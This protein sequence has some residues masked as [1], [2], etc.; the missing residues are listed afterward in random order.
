MHAKS[1]SRFISAVT[2]VAFT[3]CSLV[4]P[5]AQALAA[6][7]V[8]RFDTG[9]Y[10]VHSIDWESLG[11][12]PAKPSSKRGNDGSGPFSLISGDIAAQAL[13]IPSAEMASI[14]FTFPSNLPIVFA[15]YTPGANILR[16]D[17]FT[18]RKANG[19]TMAL[20][21][22]FGPEQ[23]TLWGAQRTYQDPAV[24]SSIYEPGPNP[25]AR[26]DQ[27]DGLFHNITQ[28]AA[29]AAVGHAMRLVGA[30]IGLLA[31]AH[32]RFDQ[33]VDSSGGLFMKTTKITVNGYTKP[34]WYVAAPKSIVP[35]G[36]T[37]AV[38]A[39]DTNPCPSYAIA[40][41]LE[42][43]QRW[44]GGDMLDNEDLLFHHEESHSGFTIFTMMLVIVV[45]NWAASEFLTA[46]MAGNAA[47]AAGAAGGATGG[48]VTTGTISNLVGG[49]LG[50]LVFGHEVALSPLAV[51]AIE[52]GSYGLLNTLK[53]GASLTDVQNGLYGSVDKGFSAPPGDLDQY[54]QDLIDATVP[55][56]TGKV[57]NSLSA[58]KGVLYGDCPP[59]SA[60][61]SCSGT[62]GIVSRDDSYIEFNSVQWVRDNGKPMLSGA[63][64]PAVQ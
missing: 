41:A 43:F 33:H 24:K 6:T 13:G 25:F 3:A 46:A 47:G 7:H 63:S 35:M 2:L 64:N 22:Q 59:G 48:A 14:I 26:F 52:G 31:V 27:G 49:H 11:E 57:T 32:Y 5:G 15:R 19:K 29:Y 55:H 36:I 28:S 60:L 54:S 1:L 20:H 4:A 18:T 38:C 17:I 10:T 45:L 40:P 61:A 58:T 12:L 44:Q 62:T 23:G 16:I 42:N 50:M 8:M 53:D 34:D 30:S 37:G 9:S 51:G 39:V 56:M 21:A